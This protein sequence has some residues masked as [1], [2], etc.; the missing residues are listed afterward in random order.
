MSPA[1]TNRPVDVKK[2][3]SKTKTRLAAQEFISHP[4]EFPSSEVMTKAARVIEH[5]VFAGK[6]IWY[7]IWIEK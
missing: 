1:E 2:I 6:G 7:Q 4:E 5:Q 3:A